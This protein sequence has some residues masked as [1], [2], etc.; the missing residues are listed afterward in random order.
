MHNVSQVNNNASSSIILLFLIIHANTHQ[1][2]QV[3]GAGRTAPMGRI[4]SLRKHE[5]KENEGYYFHMHKP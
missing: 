5:R 2:G 1:L 3:V 4:Y